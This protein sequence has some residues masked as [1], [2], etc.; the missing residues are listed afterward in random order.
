L[1]GTVSV[2]QLPSRQAF[3]GN[4]PQHLFHYTDLDGVRGI[5]TS[6]TLWLSK[7]TSTNDISEIL[8]AVEHFRAFVE[9][10]ASEF[11]KAEGDFL[12]RASDDLGGFRRT[13]ICIASFCEQD[14]LL[15]QWRGYGNDGRGIALGFSSAKILALARANGLHLYRCVYDPAAHERI[16]SDLGNML[17]ESYRAAPPR[18]AEDERA[19]VD[20][21]S[22]SFL[23]VA[24]VIKDHRFAEEREWRLVSDPLTFDDPHMIAVM[25][26]NQASVKWTLKLEGESE[27]ASS[28]IEQ[29]TIGPTL[30][31][32]N[33]SDAIEVLSRRN[34][35]RVEKI[36]IS[37]VPYR[38][39]PE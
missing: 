35:F 10:R 7:F 20:L 1:T 17:L 13:N 3:E 38:R 37:E 23:Q 34:G 27:G 6:R 26:G 11:T 9:R 32:D 15:S 33:V 12:K 14:D 4:P 21:F 39:K 16:A 25:R 2:G 36:S 30:D 24:P 31:P 5:L 28:V 22:A 8:L 18:T 19:M 29:V